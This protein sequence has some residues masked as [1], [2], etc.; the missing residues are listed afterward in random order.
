MMSEAV[1]R[2]RERSRWGL[3]GRSMQELAPAASLPR[4]PMRL[5]RAA[6]SGPAAAHQCAP[7][8]RWIHKGC[9]PRPSTRIAASDELADRLRRGDDG[10]IEALVA[11]Y[12]AWIHRVARRIVRDPRDAEEVTQDVLWTAVRKIDTFRGDAAFSSWLYRIAANAAYQRL[13]SRGPQPEVSLEPFLPVFD[14]AGRLT[15]P[16]ADWSAQLD[17][18][19]V[20]AEVR[21]AIGDAIAQLPDAYRIVFVLRDVDGVPNH[22]VAEMLG[23][24]I[25]AVKSRLHRARLALRH[26]LAEILAPVA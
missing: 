22:E 8:P 6:P 10:A 24:S 3:P 12:G 5:T 1:P 25:A 18:P 21:A 16:T 17:D 7:A 13:R 11:R 2:L 4:S 19:A 20:A 23:L 14:E 15:G 26:Q 9:A